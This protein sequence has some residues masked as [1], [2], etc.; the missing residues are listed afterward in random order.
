MMKK[1]ILGT[2]CLFIAG[3]A[4]DKPCYK[5]NCFVTETEITSDMQKI[6]SILLEYMKTQSKKQME[7]DLK[8][9]QVTC[10]LF[11]KDNKQ[12]NKEIDKLHKVYQSEQKTKE[13]KKLRKI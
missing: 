10:K 9:V 4:T 3:C 12:L 8:Y 1:I 13:N 7:Y 2:L 11:G 5:E 6:R